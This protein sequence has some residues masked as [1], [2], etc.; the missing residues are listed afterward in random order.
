MV[1]PPSVEAVEGLGWCECMEIEV[2]TRGGHGMAS[3]HGGAPPGEAGSTGWTGK[4]KIGGNHNQGQTN[5]C[6][7]D[8]NWGGGGGST[9]CAAISQQ[10][11]G[12]RIL[13]ASSGHKTFHSAASL[14][15]RQDA[16][17]NPHFTSTFNFGL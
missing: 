10:L 2:V 1:V 9:H 17:K 4:R 15:S 12:T 8:G 5:K 6:N 13:I 16:H 14:T 7:T 11:S 3:G